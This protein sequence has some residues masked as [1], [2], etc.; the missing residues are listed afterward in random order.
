[1]TPNERIQNFL[2]ERPDTI[3]SNLNAQLV[4]YFY[5][6]S[7]RPDIDTEALA[8]EIITPTDGPSPTY[9][10]VA[11]AGI[12]DFIL[13]SPPLDADYHRRLEEIAQRE[14]SAHLMK[15]ALGGALRDKHFDQAARAWSDL[16]QGP[17]SHAALH[18]FDLE[19]LL[20]NLQR[21]PF[22]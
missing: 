6:F 3:R 16:R 22:S 9:R 19:R 18:E 7:A 1:M 15:I 11:V 17:L 10:A 4:L 21:S 8:R 14:D 12:F 20:A 13:S 2:D 5:K